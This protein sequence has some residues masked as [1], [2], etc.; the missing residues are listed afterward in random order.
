[1]ATFVGAA[2]IASLILDP[3]SAALAEAKVRGQRVAAEQRSLR[4]G[5]AGQRSDARI[6][7]D[8]YVGINFC[9][10]KRCT[11][12]KR[13]HAI[14]KTEEG[15]GLCRVATQRRQWQ[16]WQQYMITAISVLG[17]DQGDCACLGNRNLG[18]TALTAKGE[19]V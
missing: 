18:S 14:R 9:A 10:S 11:A 19:H 13:E 2:G 8:Y 3:D 12:M 4:K 6:K 17:T 16:Q 5:M 15:L 7:S 1:M